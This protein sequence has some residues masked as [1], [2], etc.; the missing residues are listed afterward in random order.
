MNEFIE[1]LRK[2]MNP[3]QR[4]DYEKKGQDFFSNF[5][6]ETGKMFKVENRHTEILSALR[7][8]LDVE[9]LDQEEL[10]IMEKKFGRDW[11]NIPLE[12]LS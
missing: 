10:E 2:K 1:N 9:D 3:E 12:K 7:S 6:F 11:K 4:Q 5:D 8:G